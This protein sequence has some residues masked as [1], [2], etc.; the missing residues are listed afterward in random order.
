M[1]SHPPATAS[2]QPDGWYVQWETQKTNGGLGEGI[3]VPANLTGFAE[4]EV[5]R[6]VLAKVASGQPLRYYVGAG[7]T[8]SGDF[9]S[10]ADWKAYVAACAARI[11][12]PVK[13]T[14][15]P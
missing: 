15:T 5:N 13:V 1:V 14:L 12:S 10:E 2:S 6:L 4:D 9:A 11:K 8:K 3:I 7:W